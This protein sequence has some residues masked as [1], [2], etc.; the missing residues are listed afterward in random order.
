[1]MFAGTLQAIY[2]TDAAGEPM[3]ALDRATLITNR[4]I[5]GDRYCNSQGTFSKTQ[6]VPSSQQVTLIEAEA[7]EAVAQDQNINLDPSQ[8]RRNLVTRGVP[9]NHLIGKAFCIGNVRL[10]GMK[11]CEP[12]GYLEKVTG[13]ADLRQALLHRGGLRAQIAR[14]GEIRVG[15][16]IVPSPDS[17][18]TTAASP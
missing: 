9:L 2:I 7:I 5:E 13:H 4:G 16:A 6:H 11:L 14:G 17:V 1:M 8:T 18:A 10:R 12:C 3:R 15:Q